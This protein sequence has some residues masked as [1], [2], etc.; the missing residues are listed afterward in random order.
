MHNFKILKYFIE[1]ICRILSVNKIINYDLFDYLIFVITQTS[2]IDI[3]QCML[4]E[5]Y[6]VD[7]I[8]VKTYFI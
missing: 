2:N 5:N 6:D 3:S 4:Y 8:E 7:L 1:N